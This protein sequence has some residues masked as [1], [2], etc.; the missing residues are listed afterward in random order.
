MHIAGLVAELPCGSSSECES[1][2][3]V[4]ANGSLPSTTRAPPE[5][6]Q[7]AAPDSKSPPGR[8]V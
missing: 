2:V 1:D 8:R 4:I 6:F 3:P 5:S 7:P